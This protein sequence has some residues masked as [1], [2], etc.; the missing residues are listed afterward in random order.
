VLAVLRGNVSE[1]ISTPADPDVMGICRMIWID[2]QRQLHILP[3]HR[4]EHRPVVVWETTDVECAD[5]V[6]TILPGRFDGCRRLAAPGHLGKE[7]TAGETRFDFLICSRS[8]E[9][10]E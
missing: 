1:L 10:V 4:D 3:Q 2:R 9:P 5:N 7:V 8:S 6:R